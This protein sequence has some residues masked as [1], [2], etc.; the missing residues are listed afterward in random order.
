MTMTA[1]AALTSTT[2]TLRVLLGGV[3]IRPIAWWERR[4]LMR[5]VVGGCPDHWWKPTARRTGACTC[6]RF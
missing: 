6:D 5:G 1:P 3:P 4:S 2:P